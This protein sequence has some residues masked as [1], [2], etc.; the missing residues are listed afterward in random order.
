MWWLSRAITWYGCHFAANWPERH[1]IHFDFDLPCRFLSGKVCNCMLII[2]FLNFIRSYPW[3]SRRRV[4]FPWTHT[5]PNH[6]IVWPC[7]CAQRTYPKVEDSFFLF[8]L[9]VFSFES[10]LCW[11]MLEESSSA[12]SDLQIFIASFLFFFFV[13]EPIPRT[14]N[15]WYMHSPNLLAKLMN[16]YITQGHNWSCLRT[17]SHLEPSDDDTG[18]PATSKS[19]C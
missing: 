5:R 12:I 2:A 18:K 11:T 14:R 1:G 10:F 3:R 7:E 15:R 6:G 16:V 8:L 4:Y 9:L 13:R 19:K 17:R